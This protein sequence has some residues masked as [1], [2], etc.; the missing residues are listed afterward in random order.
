MPIQCTDGTAE[1]PEGPALPAP[2]ASGATP[3][4][5]AGATPGAMSGAIAGAMSGAMTGTT[6]GATSGAPPAGGDTLESAMA[7]ASRGAGPQDLGGRDLGGRDLADSLARLSVKFP[8]ALDCEYD[9][10]NW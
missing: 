7:L 6:A 5:T 8:P 3:R 9:F 4:T 2:R 10:L 1:R